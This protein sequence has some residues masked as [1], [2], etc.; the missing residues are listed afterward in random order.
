MIKLN[1][2]IADLNVTI[3]DMETFVSENAESLYHCDMDSQIKLDIIDSKRAIGQ[4]KAARAS[5][6]RLNR[7][8]KNKE[9]K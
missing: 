2:I 3:A 1:E 4:L 6:I 8:N 9:K 7:P 5:I